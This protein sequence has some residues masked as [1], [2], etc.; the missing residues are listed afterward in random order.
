MS[1]DS[2]QTPSSRE[3]SA[4]LLV[5]VFII[6]LCGIFYELLISSI[7]TY[8]LGSGVLHFSLTIGLFMSFMGVGSYLSRYITEP[9]LDRFITFEIWLGGVGGCSALILYFSYSLTE[10]Y[11]LVAFL[12]IAFLGCLIGLEIP[13]LTRL[14]QPNADLKDALA[15][16]LS[17]DYL[18]A[19]FASVLFPL[20]LLP[21]LGIMK[22]SFVIGILN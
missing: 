10:N 5:T 20:I 13:L 11:Y 6:A 7:S 19:L 4:V 3:V 16:A 1:A 21:Y 12:L 15:N 9:L 17:F 8:F 14:V 18:G 22:T 2:E